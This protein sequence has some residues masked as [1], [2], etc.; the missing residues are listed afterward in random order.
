M[1][2]YELIVVFDSSLEIE[3]IESELRKLQNLITRGE[4]LVRKWERWGKR[5]LAYEIRR[6]QYGYYVLVV[7]DV[8]AALV[9]ELN[10]VIRLSPTVMRHLVT[11]VDPPRV[12]EIDEESVRSLGAVVDEAADESSE[13]EVA[14]PAA[15][16]AADTA[17][18]KT[19]ESTE[20]TESAE[21]PEES[22]PSNAA[23]ETEP[24]SDETSGESKKEDPA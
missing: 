23:P 15:E 13:A 11:V 12:P 5:R 17:Q 7:F 22:P 19:T 10:R 3:Q 2:T 18:S 9:A 14:K 20:S 24:V 6:R 1:R 16:A 8:E 4:G 21:P